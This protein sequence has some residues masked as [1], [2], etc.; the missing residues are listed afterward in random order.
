MGWQTRRW[1]ELRSEKGHQIYR[2]R[3]GRKGSRDDARAP[4]RCRG[5]GHEN[6][7]PQCRHP[8]NR[9]GAESECKLGQKKREKNIILGIFYM[10][11]SVF[12]GRKE[13][14]KDMA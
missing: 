10:E 11:K 8:C 2:S 4:G 13:T 6:Y 9:D 1:R 3:R 14:T 5:D 7:Q 12:K